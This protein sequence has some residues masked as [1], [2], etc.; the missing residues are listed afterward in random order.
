MN[1]NKQRYTCDCD[2]D[3]TQEL[4]DTYV[5]SRQ[6]VIDLPAWSKARKARLKGD[7]PPNVCID[8][9]ILEAIK[10]IWDK[11]IETTGCCCG[12]GL[13]KA[14]V[15]VDPD[16]YVAMHELGYEQR[17]IEISDQGYAMGAYTFFL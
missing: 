2:P 8:T 5:F 11:G 13:M 7:Y 16:D 15:S 12:H 6:T 14:W 4:K 1:K 10:E 3:K 9:C 17:P